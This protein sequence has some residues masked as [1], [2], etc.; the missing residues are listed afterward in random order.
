MDLD[1]REQ[2]NRDVMR[3]RERSPDFLMLYIQLK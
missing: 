2:L 1:G 3:E